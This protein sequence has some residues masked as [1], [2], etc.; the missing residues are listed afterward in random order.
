MDLWNRPF[1]ILGTPT[2][3]SHVRFRNL[4]YAKRKHCTVKLSVF[5]RVFL[6]FCKFSKQ[7]V[8]NHSLKGLG[9]KIQP[10]VILIKII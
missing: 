1:P 8:T 4:K 10:Y 7:E 2:F 5:E 3:K 9:V 6:C